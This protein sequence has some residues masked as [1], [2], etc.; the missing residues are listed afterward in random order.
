MTQGKRTFYE[1]RPTILKYHMRSCWRTMSGSCLNLPQRNSLAEA[2][3]CTP[4]RYAH[5][6]FTPM[7]LGFGPGDEHWDDALRTLTINT[8]CGSVWRSISAFV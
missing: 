8:F 6:A 7:V 3:S 4:V 1:S 5:G 2:V